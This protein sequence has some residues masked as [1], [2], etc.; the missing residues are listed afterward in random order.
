MEEIRR[1]L[2]DSGSNIVEEDYRGCS[3]TDDDYVEEQKEMFDNSF[4]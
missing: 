1:L 2:F 3:A 4:R